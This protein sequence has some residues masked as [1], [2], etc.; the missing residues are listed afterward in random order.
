MTH[1]TQTTNREEHHKGK[2]PVPDTKTGDEGSA[3]RNIQRKHDHDPNR[4]EKKN[5]GGAGGK[6]KWNDLD[7]GTVPDEEEEE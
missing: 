4:K 3:K 5:H 6:G 1:I 7:D 2:T